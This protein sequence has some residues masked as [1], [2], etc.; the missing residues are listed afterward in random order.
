MIDHTDDVQPARRG[1]FTKGVSGNPAGRPR[2]SRNATTIAIEQLLDGEAQ[3]IARVAIEKAKAGDPIAL[4]LVMERVA[5]VRRGRPV[6]FDLPDLEKAADL[7]PAM[8]GVLMATAAGDLTPE[9]A[10]VI[11][12]LL[13]T[14]RR[15]IETGDLERRLEQL[16]ERVKR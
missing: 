3:T 15:A 10:S 4:R 14:K 9:E 11:A 7:A 16:E 13:E 2:G 6:Q 1:G 5:P 8:A 12:G